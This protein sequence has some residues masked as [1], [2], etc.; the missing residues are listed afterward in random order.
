LLNLGLKQVKNKFSPK[1]VHLLP[2]TDCVERC[3]F[4]GQLQWFVVVNA[5]KIGVGKRVFSNC[6]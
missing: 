2:E 3:E 4:W 6:V 5:H 1:I